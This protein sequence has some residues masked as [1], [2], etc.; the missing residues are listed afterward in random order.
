MK[1]RWG[2]TAQ[3]ARLVRI[4]RIDQEGKGHLS[5]LGGPFT[6]SEIVEEDGGVEAFQLKKKIGE[7]AFL[8]WFIEL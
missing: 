7:M 5:D 6:R 2:N 1:M 8:G 4:S 3:W